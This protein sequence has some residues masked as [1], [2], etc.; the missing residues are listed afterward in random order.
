MHESDPV[1]VLRTNVDLAQQIL[2][3]GGDPSLDI[4]I[5]LER[6]IAAHNLLT[7]AITTA[8][9]IAIPYKEI[10]NVRDD[11]PV[12]EFLNE[13]NLT[14]RARNAITRIMEIPTGMFKGSG[15]LTPD[16]EDFV[17]IKQNGPIDTFGK[18]HKT[19]TGTVLSKLRNCGDTTVKEI[20]SAMARFVEH[21]MDS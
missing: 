19:L 3:A 14:V 18:L 7:E 4:S 10:P 15:Y 1:R 5:C 8:R 13:A 21:K 2:E 20:R 11:A 12:E 17:R 9:Q 6:A 16:S